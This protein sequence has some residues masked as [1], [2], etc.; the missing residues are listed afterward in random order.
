MFLFDY[1]CEASL[2]KRKHLQ[3]EPNI[4]IVK[5]NLNFAKSF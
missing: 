4:H 5:N 2:S 3:H 1:D